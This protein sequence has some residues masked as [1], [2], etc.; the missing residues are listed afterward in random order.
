MEVDNILARNITAIGD[1]A[2]YDSACKRLLAN[3]VI[4]A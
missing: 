1:K 3:K 4:L 2:A